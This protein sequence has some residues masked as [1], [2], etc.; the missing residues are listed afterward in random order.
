MTSDMFATKH[1]QPLN[2]PRED[3][4]LNGRD[5]SI[6]WTSAPHYVPTYPHWQELRAVRYNPR[7]TRKN[8]GDYEVEADW[9]EYHRQRQTPSGYYG[10]SIG[11]QPTGVPALRLDGYTRHIHGMPPRDVFL[12]TWPKSDGWMEPARAPRGEYYGYYHEALESERFTRDRLRSMHERITPFDVPRI[13]S[14][15]CKQV[16]RDVDCDLG[17]GLT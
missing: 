14:L 15:N 12:Y 3:V 17:C 11:T 9:T 1:E 16:F 2:L 8:N 4:F 10:H 5:K 6:I 7:L 13:T